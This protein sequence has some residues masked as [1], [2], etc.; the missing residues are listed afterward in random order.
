[1]YFKN[2]MAK[3]VFIPRLPRQRVWLTTEHFDITPNQKNYESEVATYT[4][5]KK[6]VL[7]IPDEFIRLKLMTA[8]RFSFATPAGVD[9]HTLTLTY[10]ITRD[11]LILLEGANVILVKTSP[12][13]KEE[14]PVANYTVTEPKTVTI[15]KLVGG[16]TY[17]FTAYYLFGGGIDGGSVNVTVISADETIREKI[18]EAS[19]IRSNRVSRRVNMVNQED[20]ST[21]LKPGL[22]PGRV[23]FCLPESFKL[24]VRVKTPAPIVFYHP[25]IDIGAQSPY[26]RESFI[27]FPVDVSNLSE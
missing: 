9:T 27:E 25:T 23:D 20:V 24:Q 18:L 5:P 26:A 2:H 19:I 15:R 14:W 12:A 6:R 11:K 7:E 13:P 4:V 1:M 22:K 10:P 8:E 3:Q 21:E 16:T 17:E